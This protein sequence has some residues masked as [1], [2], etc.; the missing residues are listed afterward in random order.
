MYE[1]RY[2]DSLGRYVEEGWSLLRSAKERRF[3]LMQ[4]GLGV[5]TN[6]WRVEK[7]SEP[8]LVNGRQK[9]KVRSRA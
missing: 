9:R 1:V 5:E 7:R 4:Q 6:I 2:H 8:V 3:E